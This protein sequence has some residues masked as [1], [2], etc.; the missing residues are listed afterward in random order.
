MAPSNGVISLNVTEDERPELVEFYKARLDKLESEVL[1]AQKILQ[2]LGYEGPF[3]LVEASTS[4]EKTSDRDQYRWNWSWTLKI[5]FVLQTAG[6]CLTT[7][8]IIE[9]IVKNEP[10]LKRSSIVNSVS[11]TISAKVTKGI[12]FKRY[13]DYPGGDYYVGLSEWFEGNEVKPEHKW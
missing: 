5:K 6:K 11:G 1:K 7:R 9:G 13:Q 3:R 12:L 2:T 8:E 4:N 10:E